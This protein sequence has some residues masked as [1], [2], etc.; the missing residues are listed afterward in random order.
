LKVAFFISS[1][2]NVDDS[3]GHNFTYSSRRTFFDREE[4]YRQTQFTLASLRLAY[5]GCMIYLYDCSRNPDEYRERFAYMGTDNFRYISIQELDP[6]INEICRTHP[7]KGYCEALCTEVFL[8]NYIDELREYDYIVKISG[9]YFYTSF[10]A[11]VLNEQNKNSFLNK[12]IRV[13]DWQPHWN[14][15]EELNRNGYMHWAPSQTYAVGQGQI[16][17]YYRTYFNIADWYRQ[18]PSIGGIVDF[19]A[20]FYHVLLSHFPIVEVPWLTGGWGGSEGDYSE[21]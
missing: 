19:E 12:Y 1:V 13:W 11:T 15:P 10:D 8:K 5:P 2:I 20:I 16:D 7:A 3:A 9:R 17:N 6:E 21:W 4:R 14:Y 18:N